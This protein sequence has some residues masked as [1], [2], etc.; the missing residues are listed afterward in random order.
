MSDFPPPRAAY[1]H[2]PFCAYRCGY[3]NFTLVSGRDD[4]VQPY[5][6]ALEQE[7]SGLGTPQPV[8]TLFF[9]GGTPTRLR[10]DDLRRLLAST[11]YWLPPATG[12]EISI[13]A[14]PNDVDPECLEILVEHGVTR[15]SLGGQSFDAAKLKRLE[16]THCGDELTRAI[17]LSRAALPQ[18]SVDLIFGVPGETLD[19]W[20]RDLAKVIE[21]APQHVSTYG[22]TF[23]RG[24]T[25][26][27]RLS[28]GQLQQADEE[29][30]RALYEM[31]IESLT[32]SG[33]EHYEISNF[34]RPGSACRHNQTYW[35]GDSYFA[36]GPGAARYV[37]GRR[38]MNHRSTTTWLKRIAAGQS[39][40][41]ESEI[42]SA[43]DR[44]R[45]LLVFGMRRL[46]GV[47][48]RDFRQRTCFE[49]AQLAGEHLGNFIERGLLVAE[50]N[51]LRLSRA[52]LLVS[53]SIWPYFLRK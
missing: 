39:P 21:L 33:Y 45:E 26:W 48:L 15:I 47:N 35:A 1:V 52:G 42:L 10:G 51:R 38:E 34:A 28:K 27:S 20:Q 25:F 11:L 41:A 2:V 14:N 5:L 29:L 36:F 32:G 9:G 6:G 49:V 13:E 44:A 16:R 37:D 24:T 31:A 46:A 43:E 30:E 22:L 3:C 17:E 23:E 8:D 40:V 4:L 7:L 53:D 19:V 12:A 50:P 18:V